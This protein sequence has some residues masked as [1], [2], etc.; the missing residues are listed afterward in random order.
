MKDRL[1]TKLGTSR[2]KISVDSQNR[3]QQ[4]ILFFSFQLKMRKIIELSEEYRSLRIKVIKGDSE[5]ADELWLVLEKQSQYQNI[6]AVNIN[7]PEVRRPIALKG[8][9]KPFRVIDVV[10]THKDRHI[11]VHVRLSEHPNFYS[12]LVRIDRD[13]QCKEL[14]CEEASNIK[15]VADVKGIIQVLKS[16]RVYVGG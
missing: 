10:Q 2:N 3:K 11:V 16:A 5:L 9:S 14:I 1:E 15:A 4:Y 13:G 8:F 12:Q 6:L 7:N